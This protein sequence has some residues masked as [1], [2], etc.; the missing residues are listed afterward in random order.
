VRREAASKADQCRH[1]GRTAR[2][3]GRHAGKSMQAGNVRQ[4]G[5]QGKSGRQSEQCMQAGRPIHGGKKVKQFKA[6]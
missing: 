3:V 2:Q 6:R 5:N 4:A 1:T